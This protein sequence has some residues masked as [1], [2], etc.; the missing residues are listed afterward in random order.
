MDLTAKHYDGLRD[1]TEHPDDPKP[2]ALDALQARRRAIDEGRLK[3]P[4]RDELPPYVVVEHP[5]D[6]IPPLASQETHPG[7]VVPENQT[8]P[9]G[10]VDPS[11]P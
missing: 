7:P 2:H 6:P 10:T 4:P 8:A 11:Q 3:A 9:A 1:A 5:A